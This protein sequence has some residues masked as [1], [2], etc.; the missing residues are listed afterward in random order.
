VGS[1]DFQQAK[2]LVDRKAREVALA[3]YNGLLQ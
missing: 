2:K 1:F 3:H